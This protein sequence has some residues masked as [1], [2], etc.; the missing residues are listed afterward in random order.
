MAAFAGVELV[1]PPHFG[2]LSQRRPNT[3][4]TSQPPLSNGCCSCLQSG[5]L[6]LRR[7]LLANSIQ[8]SVIPSD[9]P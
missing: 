6:V 2:R 3:H 5:F 9:S 7:M 8:T 1:L 4:S